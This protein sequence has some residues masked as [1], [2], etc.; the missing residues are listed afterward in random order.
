MLATATSGRGVELIVGVAGSGKTTALAA[1]REAFEAEGYRVMGTSTS[2]QA[3]RTLGRAA[4]IDPSRH[5]VSHALW[6]LRQA[7]ISIAGIEANVACSGTT[8]ADRRRWRTE[9]ADWEPKHAVA[10]RA[11]AD[12]SGPEIARIDVEDRKVGVRLPDLWGQRETHQRWAERASRGGSPPRPPHQRNR[13]PEQ[14]PG[15]RRPPSRPRPWL[16]RTP[17]E[18]GQHRPRSQPRP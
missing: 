4:G 16:R 15:R 6:E 18:A 14:E 3:A 17:G 13:L 12:L 2:G 8:R 7:E 1:L 9:L 11:V 5:P 10:V